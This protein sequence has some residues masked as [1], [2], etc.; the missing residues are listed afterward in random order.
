MVAS[1][2][3][4]LPGFLQAL[5]I[6]NEPTSTAAHLKDDPL[7]LCYSHLAYAL[8]E[9]TDCDYGVAFKSIIWASDMS[10]LV[11]VIPRLHIPGAKSAELA[12]DLQHRVSAFRNQ[13]M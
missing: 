11:A 7:S 1:S 6:S 10:H 4:D 12:A 8:V 9:L 5:G 2:V 13:S 3:D